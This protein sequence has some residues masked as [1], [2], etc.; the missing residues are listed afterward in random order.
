MPHGQG[1]AYWTEL[2]SGGGNGKEDAFNSLVGQIW[3]PLVG[4]LA[5][6]FSGAEEWQIVESAEDALLTYWSNPRRFDPG[7]RVPLRCYLAMTAEGY[8]RHRLRGERRR[9]RWEQTGLSWDEKSEEKTRPRVTGGVERAIPI[10]GA[11]EA[12]EAELQRREFERRLTLLKPCERAL[13]ELWLRGVDTLEAWA[14]AMGVGHLP[15][16]EKDRQVRT[17]K[18]SLKRKLRKPPAGGPDGASSYGAIGRAPRCCGISYGPCS[19]GGVI[20]GRPR[21]L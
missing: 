21:S 2:H 3:E 8:L 4:A 19:A 1:D 14:E 16:E 6:H 12:D 18:M 13:V 11:N 10:G 17:K 15:R 9:R 5:R 7:R 20:L